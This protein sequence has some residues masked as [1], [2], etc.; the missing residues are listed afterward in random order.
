MPLANDMRWQ[1]GSKLNLNG[2]PIRRKENSILILLPKQL[3]RSVGK[4]A[5]PY[6]KGRVGYWDT[7]VV[8]LVEQDVDTVYT[9]HYPE[10]H[11]GVRRYLSVSSDAKTIKGEKRGYLTGILYLA[12]ASTSGIANVCAHAT[13]GCMDSC[14]N[15][16]GR[17][18]VY[19]AIIRAR[20]RKTRELFADRGKFTAALKRDIDTLVRRARKRALTPCVRVNG[21]SDLP[22]LARE[23]ARAFPKVQFYDYTKHPRAWE[24]TMDNYHLTFSHSESNH[25]D[26][27]ACLSRGINIAVVFDTRKGQPLPEKWHGY[28]VVDGDVS[29][30]RFADPSGV[31]V[32]LRAK[33]RARHDC[34]GFVQPVRLVQL[35]GR[36]AA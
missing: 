30:L 24:R 31:V 13:R 35:Q 2:L 32:G 4:C 23:L 14:L 16:A 26:A 25:L 18:S 34:S 29:D 10:L 6:C 33:G 7:V 36:I 20:I 15:T 27:M 3:W 17:A 22:W 5:C 28:R 8:P 9:V 12:P 11:K 21:T 19:P 1:M